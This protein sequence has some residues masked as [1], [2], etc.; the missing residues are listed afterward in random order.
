MAARCGVEYLHMIEEVEKGNI[1][2][3]L[4][5]FFNSCILLD[6]GLSLLENRV[7]TSFIKDFQHRLLTDVESTDIES[8]TV[9]IDFEKSMLK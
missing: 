3:K 7:L 1:I 5:V 4:K 6:F 2:Q 8:N 9:N